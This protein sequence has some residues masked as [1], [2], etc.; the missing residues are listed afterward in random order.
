VI[1]SIRVQGA[2]AELTG[3]P[4]SILEESLCALD[5]KR[6]FNA[7][8]RQKRWDGKVRLHSGRLFP[9]G[10]VHRVIAA[11]NEDGMDVRVV[12]A[13]ETEPID[14]SRFDKHYLPGIELWDHQIK[15]VLAMLQNPRGSIKSPTG[16]GK[17]EMIAAAARY[18]WEER[19]WRSLVVVPKKGLAAQQRERMRKYYGDDIQVG[20]CGD[21]HRIVGPITVAT[22]QTLAGFKPRIQKVRGKGLK[23]LP[24]DPIL[25]KLV[26][27]CEVLFLDETHHASS[28]SWFDIAMSSGAIRR[29]GLSGTPLKEDDVA[30]LRMVGATGPLLCEIQA[31][32]MIDLGLCARPKIAVVMSDAVSGPELPFKWLFRIQKDGSRVRYKRFQPYDVAYQK[33]VVDNRAHNKAVIRATNWLVDQDKQT[34]VLCRRKDH[35]SALKKMLEDTGVQFMAVWGD[36]ETEERNRAKKALDSRRIQCVLASTIWDEGEDVPGIEALVLAEGVK[37]NTNV[38]QRIGRGMRR[39]KGGDN[40]VWVVDFAPTCHP[41]LLEHA[42]KRAESYEGEGYEVRV[43]EEWRTDEDFDEKELL[44]FLNWDSGGTTSEQTEPKK[45]V[46]SAGAGSPNVAR[47][48]RT[49]PVRRGHPVRVVSPQS[50]KPV[51]KGREL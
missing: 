31:T 5:P 30:D 14:V 47:A 10:L 50:G 15:A 43:V 24:A 19:R 35:F 9:S 40:T 36:T 3:A 45:R 13:E 39:K 4:I 1:P 27:Q 26:A 6:F 38:L 18:F 25:R 17:G 11:C 12:S 29:F 23:H 16:S 32:K 48:S 33:G 42:L 46:A 28:D 7:A 41:K 49:E 34:L 22:A 8:F 51:R 37:V 44:P 20:I 21:G 2:W